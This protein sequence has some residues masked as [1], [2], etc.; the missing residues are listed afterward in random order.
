[1]KIVFKA[2]MRLKSGKRQTRIWLSWNCE[3][4]FTF[5]LSLF[6]SFF[7]LC[8]HV[9]ILP[10]FGST[11]CPPVCFFYVCPSLLWL[12]VFTSVYFHQI[13]QYK[14]KLWIA[15][16][17]DLKFTFR[18]QGRTGQLFDSRRPLELCTGNTLA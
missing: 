8:L 5:F 9:T 14:E 18:F 17:Q 7:F 10:Y 15:T 6:S 16:I 11:L 3:N 13:E 12:S 1:M 2:E 4:I